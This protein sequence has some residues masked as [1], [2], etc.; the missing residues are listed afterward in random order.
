MTQTPPIPLGPFD[1]I[2]PF[3]QGG[4]ASVW[5]GRH[6]SSGLPVAVKVLEGS[7][8]IDSMFKDAFA[9][10]VHI[11][12]R[13]HGPM[14]TIAPGERG[15]AVNSIDGGCEPNICGDA[16]AAIFAPTA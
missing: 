14:S 9:A 10:E 8:A 3:G 11:V 7:L 2:A 16:Q 6:R 12:A 5:R 1:L 13:S 15:Y 4:M